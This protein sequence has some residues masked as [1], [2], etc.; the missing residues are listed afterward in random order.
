MLL[1]IYKYLFSVGTVL[2]LLAAC[3]DNDIKEEKTDEKVAF[4][5]RLNNI[6][7]ENYSFRN[8]EFKYDHEVTGVD[9]KGND[10]RGNI[11]IEG[12]HGE[13]KLYNV[14]D[15]PEINIVIESNENGKLIATD[16]DGNKFY[17]QIK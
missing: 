12:E 14:L 1:K 3:K 13:G 9:E 15:K 4:H 5:H 6:Q 7:I 10:I 2:F 17:L 8:T 11:N 16:A